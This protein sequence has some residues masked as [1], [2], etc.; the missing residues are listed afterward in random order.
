MVDLL[1]LGEFPARE[2]AAAIEAPLGIL[3][4]MVDPIHGVSSAACRLPELDAIIIN[5]TESPRRQN[6]DIS[7]ELFHILTWET[8]PPERI[9]TAEQV[10]DS[11]VGRKAA[12][13]V[14][15]EQLADNFSSG[16]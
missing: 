12:R 5:R 6:A 4:L 1:D 7:H 8:M 15:T 16:L 11:P 3:M 10:W 14:R 2:L 13:N 9:E